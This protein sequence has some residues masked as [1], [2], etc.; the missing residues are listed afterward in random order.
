MAIRVRGCARRQSLGHQNRDSLQC[1]ALRWAEFFRGRRGVCGGFRKCAT[2][3]ACQHGDAPCWAFFM[4][5]RALLCEIFERW[6]A[7]RRALRRAF[8]EMSAS[9]RAESGIFVDFIF[10]R[11][12]I[13][14]SGQLFCVFEKTAHGMHLR[15]CANVREAK[16]LTTKSPP[17]KEGTRKGTGLGGNAEERQLTAKIATHRLAEP[18]SGRQSAGGRG[19]A[20]DWSW[21]RAPF[22]G[23][24]RTE[25]RP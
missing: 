14:S 12:V 19:E 2:Q 18:R 3:N 24:L 23:E 13:W 10:L 6:R 8:V 11:G 15:S 9:V 25:R 21:I 22:G 5:F 1:A 7:L 20:S 16:S 4:R 17:H